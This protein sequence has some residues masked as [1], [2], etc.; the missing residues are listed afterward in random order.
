MAVLEKIPLENLTVVEEVVPI[1]RRLKYPVYL[2]GGTVRDLYLGVESW[3]MDFV[4]E[5]SGLKCATKY[6][7]LKEAIVKE[8]PVFLTAS[9]RVQDKRIDFAS[10]REEKYRKP[11]DYPKVKAST[12]AQDLKRRDFTINAMALSL[13]EEN[14]GE[15]ID[16][17]KGLED[18]KAKKV[19]VLHDK[20]FLDDP[21]RIFRA[22]RFSCRFGFEVEE[23]TLNLVKSAIEGGALE[24]I[25]RYR[26]QQELDKIYL[27]P[28]PKQCL[29]DLREWGGSAIMEFL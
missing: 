18:L 10:A 9:V 5:G 22:A 1:A 4:F 29:N 26:I 12:L 20:S 13:N 8:H 27:E 19:R 25:T 24:T 16:P 2:V 21:S 15:L 3:D 28:D 7:D 17:L 6:A 11:G 23:K 14:Y